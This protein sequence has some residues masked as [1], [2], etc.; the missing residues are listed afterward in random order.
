MERTYYTLN[1]LPTLQISLNKVTYYIS[2][3]I[4]TNYRQGILI[5]YINIA[6]FLQTLEISSPF[7]P[8]S[9]NGKLGWY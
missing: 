6:D 4:K 9:K 2:I 5:I 8:V 3:N 7:L 1:K